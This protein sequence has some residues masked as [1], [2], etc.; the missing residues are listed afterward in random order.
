MPG[1]CVADKTDCNDTDRDINLGREDANSDRAD[2]NCNGRRD[3]GCPL[4]P[5]PPYLNFSSTEGLSTLIDCDP[6]MPSE[7][8]SEE[9]Q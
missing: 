1:G 2:N 5:D 6:F 9:V 4:C 8:V 3:E 7:Y